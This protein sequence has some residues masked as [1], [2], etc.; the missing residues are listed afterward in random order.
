MYQE[1]RHTYGGANGKLL[2]P[3][4]FCHENELPEEAAVREV[5]EETGISAAVKRMAGIRCER[6]S[7][8]K[9]RKAGP[10]AH[11]DHEFLQCTQFFFYLNM[12]LLFL[13]MK[14]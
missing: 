9:R 3:G 14:V 6:N 13:K 8:L 11:S 7:W 12:P 1:F 2:I 4:G 5:S 10:D